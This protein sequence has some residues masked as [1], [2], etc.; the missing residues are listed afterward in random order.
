MSTLLVSA[1]PL[2]IRRQLGIRE[3]TLDDLKRDFSYSLLF[4]PTVNLANYIS[5][6][7]LPTYGLININSSMYFQYIHFSFFFFTRI[8]D[9][10]CL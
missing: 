10:C 4:L 2:G 5:L 8:D 9:L 3:G 1:P 6:L 7:W